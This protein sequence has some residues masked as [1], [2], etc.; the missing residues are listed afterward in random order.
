MDN[1]LFLLFPPEL[2]LI[3]QI[4]DRKLMSAEEISKME[5]LNEDDNPVI[6]KYYLKK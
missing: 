2:D 4:V 6:V 3:S 1:V 5:A